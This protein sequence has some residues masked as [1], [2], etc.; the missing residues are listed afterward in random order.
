MKLSKKSRRDFFKNIYTLSIIS[1]T[2]PFSSCVLSSSRIRFGLSTDSHYAET[3]PRGTRFYRQSL[4][5][6]QEFID[7]MNQS[8]VDFIINL[9]DFKDEAA[10]GKETDTLHFLKSI[11]SVF[12]T[13]NGP[14]Y[15]CVGNH[16]VD[17]ITK[18]LFLSNIEN[19]GISKDKSYY[20]FDMKDF[21]FIVLDPNYTAEGKDHYY[22]EGAD[23]QNTNIP[24]EQIE[25]LKNDLQRSKY[26]SIVFCHQLLFHHIGNGHQYNVNNYLE[27]HEILKQHNV[28]A[29]FQGHVHKEI[30]KEIDDIHYISQLGMVDFDGLD[31]NSFAIIEI[32]SSEV[33]IE[34]YKRSS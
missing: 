31:N 12:Q 2:L 23:W 19:T 17:S 30:Y 22:K 13:F 4:N 27:I 29:V 16:D 28:L 18:S 33:K 32:N 10:G 5:K 21:H 26:P 3:N 1:L 6:M 34:G 20:S 25:W 9:G 7:V 8:E 11:E 14:T 15:H 24:K